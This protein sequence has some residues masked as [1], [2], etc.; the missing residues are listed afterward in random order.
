MKKITLAAVLIGA[1][2]MPSLAFAQA[3]TTPSTGV[4]KPAVTQPTDSNNQTPPLKG[5]QSFT[6]A[7]ANSRIES[8]GYTEV[9]NLTL[10]TTGLWT[11]SAM[12]DGKAVTVVLDYQG[13]VVTR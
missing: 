7:Q 1:A 9:R 12:K 4:D 11:G 5:A 8:S 6:Q 2:V 3:T 10:D 13:N